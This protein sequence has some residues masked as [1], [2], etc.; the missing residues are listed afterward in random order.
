M[1]RE[2]DDPCRDA[3]EPREAHR[4]IRQAIGSGSTV[5]SPHFV[6]RLTDRGLDMQDCINVLTS[7]TVD[8]PELEKGSWRYRVRTQHIEVIVTFRSATEIVLVSAWGRQR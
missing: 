6:K 1:S 5:I 2:A 3:L 4:L 7:G 8:P